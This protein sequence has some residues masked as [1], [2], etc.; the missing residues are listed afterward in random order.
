MNN[1]GKY[2]GKP[3]Y[4]W[5]IDHIIP[6]SSGTS[7]EDILFINRY[8]NLRPLCS[9]INRCIKRNRLDLY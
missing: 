4:G 1:Y 9:Y 7:I 8:T 2:N 3:N 5:D 6:V